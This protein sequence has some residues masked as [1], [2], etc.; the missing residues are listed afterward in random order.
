MGGQYD[1]LAFLQSA[2]E[3]AGVRI[4]QAGNEDGHR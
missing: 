3:G 2:H 1:I 4:L